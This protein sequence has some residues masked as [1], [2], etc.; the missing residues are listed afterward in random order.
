MSFS[1]TRLANSRAI[2]KG[3]DAHGGSGSCVVYTQQ[4]DE[5]KAESSYSDAL[6]DFNE[7]V[8]E[9]FAPLLAAA[10]AA[11]AAAVV[12]PDDPIEYV[13]LQDAVEGVEATPRQLIHLT[14]DSIVLRLIEEG[15]SDRLI[16]VDGGLEILELAPVL[17]DDN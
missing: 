16:W 7:A 10:E 13:V 12:K 8:E 1:I 15:D 6:D 11:E 4:W 14:H 17:S 2:V 5:I 9:F 3:E